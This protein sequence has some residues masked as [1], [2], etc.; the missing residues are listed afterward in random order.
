MVWFPG[1]VALVTGAGSGIGR[2]SALKFAHEGAKVI[3]SGIVVE[4]GYETVL[5]WQFGTSVQKNRRR[6]PTS[7]V[8]N[9]RRDFSGIGEN[10]LFV[11]R[12]STRLNSSHSQ[13]SYA[14][15]CLKKK[16]KILVID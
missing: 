5:C 6:V 14:V 15:F 11:D 2:A 12:K 16:C 1:K 10:V 13:I 3:V 8:V 7:C 9:L 4:G